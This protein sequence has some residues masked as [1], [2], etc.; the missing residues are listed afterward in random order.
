MIQEARSVYLL[1]TTPNMQEMS[2]DS[3]T[4]RKVGLYTVEMVKWIG[5]TWSEFYKIKMIDRASGYVDPDEDFKL[6]EED[7]DI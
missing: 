1:G 6:E 5:K 3:S 7:Q 2:T 4:L